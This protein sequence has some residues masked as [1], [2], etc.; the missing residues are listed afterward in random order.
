[1][2]DFDVVGQKDDVDV[3]GDFGIPCPIFRDNIIIEIFWEAGGEPAEL[4]GCFAQL[5][6]LAVLTLEICGRG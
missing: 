6:R 4:E 3:K 1:V 2:H 5:L